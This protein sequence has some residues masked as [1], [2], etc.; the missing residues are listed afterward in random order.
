MA[1]HGI[2][3]RLSR[4]AR[5]GAWPFWLVAAA[6]AAAFGTW[7]WIFP[8]SND[9]YWYAAWQTDFLEGA[10]SNPWPGIVESWKYRWATDNTR[11]ANMLYTVV[12]GMPGWLTLP[13]TVAAV[14]LWYV[15]TARVAGAGTR[16][17][18][19]AMAI[20][21]LVSALPMWRIEMISRC[22]QFNYLWSTPLALWVACLSLD[23]GRRGLMAMALW[24][25]VAGMWHEGFSMPLAAGL[26][27]L[28]CVRPSQYLDRRRV[29]LLAGLLAGI[30]V[31]S[32]APGTGLRMAGVS[33]DFVINR[34][35]IMTVSPALLLYIGAMAMAVVC[36]RVRRA[37]DWHLHLYLAPGIL[38]GMALVV[39][40][41]ATRSGWCMA[42][43]CIVG[44]CNIG[45]TAAREYRRLRPALCAAVVLL[46]ATAAVKMYYTWKGT[47]KILPMIESARSAMLDT[48]GESVFVPMISPF[49]GAAEA[50]IWPF[51]YDVALEDFSG[52]WFARYHGRESV[53]KVIPAELCGVTADSGEP[54]PG[55]PGLRRI[56]QQYYLPADSVPE[57]DPRE[58]RFI[59]A[60]VS[61]GP[62]HRDYLMLYRPFTSQA[63]GL[64]YLWVAPL[65]TTRYLIPYG[66]DSMRIEWLPAQQ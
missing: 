28:M 64:R 20:V 62:L 55:T 57:F 26:G 13:C 5:G 66:V 11:L 7:L 56:G 9:D 16:S 63:D 39:W 3:N 21:G 51:Y 48:D 25:F 36:G 18:W 54:V 60:H 12:L 19:V 43:L 17:A 15:L 32:M 46:F 49:D 27:T 30:A 45:M 35:A 10:T 44:I 53:A 29:W 14:L 58:K 61:H 1:L 59:P 2:C 6:F 42:A 23:P 31:L 52:A 50:L 4:P 8:M 33:R 37:L 38:V 34:Y 41:Q 65:I 22:Y 24:G 47:A 40:T